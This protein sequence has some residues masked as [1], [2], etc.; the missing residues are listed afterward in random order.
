[1]RRLSQRVLIALTLFTCAFPVLSEGADKIGVLLKGR[2]PF[3]ASME[4]GATEAGA[5]LGADVT[6]RAPASEADVSVQIQLLNAMAGQGFAAIVIV[7]ANKDALAAPVAAL[8]A[9]G[10]KI[11]VLE[12]PLGG[13]KWPVFVSTDH[14]VAG[15]A[16]GKLVASLVGETDEISFLNHSQTNSATTAR[17]RAA[18]AAIREAR[19]KALVHAA[20][21][22]ASSQA[23][24]EPEKARLLLTQFPAT[25]AIFASGTTGT[26]AML[27]VLQE[28]KIAGKIKLVGFGFNLSSDIAAAIQDGHM[29][30]WI[31]WQPRELGARGVEAAVALLKGD[32]VP[33]VV[34]TDFVVVTPAN[35]GEAKVQALLAQ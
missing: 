35:L 3:W 21:I 22:Y 4:K 9:K 31:A 2:S 32:S 12:S 6:V 7:P 15:Q 30:G 5:K 10:V 25:K 29:H 23:G 26:L 14:S 24:T 1:M 11:V 27:K 20:D 17:E 13:D 18:L 28:K 16:A 8:A 19:P 33:A 34:N